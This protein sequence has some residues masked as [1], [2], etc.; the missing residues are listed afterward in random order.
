MVFKIV[1]PQG[2]KRIGE[3][4]GDTLIK[5]V[6]RSRHFH[7]KFKAWGIQQEAIPRLER[8]KVKHIRLEVKD[9]GEVL[10]APLEVLKA[11]GFSFDFG[12]GKQIFLREEYWQPLNNRQLS[13]FE[14]V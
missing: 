4:K 6:Q 12:H 9:T 3:V 7:R 1:T 8:L 10:V 2:L 13:L 5:H 14:V 11:R